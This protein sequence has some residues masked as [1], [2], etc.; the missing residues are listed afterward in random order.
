MDMLLFYVLNS[1][2]IALPVCVSLS[3]E[4]IGLATDLTQS[5]PSIHVSKRLLFSIVHE[6]SGGRQTVLTITA[7]GQGQ[8]GLHFQWVLWGPRQCVVILLEQDIDRVNLLPKMQRQ[9]SHYKEIVLTLFI[10]PTLFQTHMLL[11]SVK[12]KRRIV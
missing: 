6:K 7:S 9:F 5:P 3:G 11:Y 1:E 4:R 8:A 10:H 2:L 12:E